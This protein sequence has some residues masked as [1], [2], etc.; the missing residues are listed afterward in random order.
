M[1]APTPVQG[2]APPAGRAS[3]RRRVSLV[4]ASITTVVAVVAFVLVV[5]RDWRLDDSVAID[6]TM[7]L[8]DDQDRL[9]AQQYDDDERIDVEPS[10][11]DVTVARYDPTGVLDEVEGPLDEDAMEEIATLLE[12]ET[13][14]EFD[15]VGDEV[16]LDDRA[17]SAA[18][19]GCVEPEACSWLVIARPVTTFA[20]HLRDRLGWLFVCALLAALA[21]ALAARWTV[22]RS[23]RA[24]DAMRREVD[25]IT[26]ADLARRVPVPPTGDE[27]QT[28]AESFNATIERLERGVDA[29]RRFTSDAAHEL[30]SPLAGVRAVLEV[31]Q[32]QPER[33]PASVD[34]ALDQLD[35]AGRLVDDLLV[36]ASHDAA[37]PQKR[38]V[39]D[40]DDI[41]RREAR[42]VAA[43]FGDLVVDRS[44]V[45]P[46]Q[47]SVTPAAIGRVVQNLV[48][49]AAAH[50]RRTVRLRL[51]TVVAADGDG[52]PVVYWQL[53]VDDDGPGVPP[54]AR[55]RVFERFAR[56]DEARS[57]HAGGTGLGL[58]I[59]R[60]LVAEHGGTVAVGDSD[61]G[62]AS[63]VVRVPVPLPG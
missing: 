48:D 25:E 3:L 60:E 1:S 36:L 50:A 27:L 7:D 22:G 56:L 12:I 30:R 53:G 49:N 42:A 21:A 39:T 51:S 17:Y 45:L 62:G 24:V 37:A 6:E 11:G 54:A 20:D 16:D 55:E 61:L 41:V 8:V 31:A 5:H 2:T 32:R 23:L 47:A 28:L 63:F 46:V 18:A 15:I 9:I 10:T 14:D 52:R 38:V 44:G 29:Q 13:L 35:R 40:I 58:A 57:R 43:R 59:V 33:M 26:T 34:A 4:G 19:T